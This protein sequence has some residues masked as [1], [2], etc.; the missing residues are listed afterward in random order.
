MDRQKHSL[1]W[2]KFI[3]IILKREKNNLFSIGNKRARKINYSVKISI[4]AT[5]ILAIL[6]ILLFL[7]FS[8]ANTI[9]LSNIDSQYYYLLN[10]ADIMYRI[11]NA[12]IVEITRNGIEACT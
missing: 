8:C 9:F 2:N 5:S 10:T 1:F 12:I 3:I 7:D 6:A 11:Y 4:L